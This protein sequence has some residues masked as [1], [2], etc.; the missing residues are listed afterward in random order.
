MRFLKLGAGL[1]SQKFDLEALNFG[2]K[3][4]KKNLDVCISILGNTVIFFSI[5]LLNQLSPVLIKTAFW[6]MEILRKMV[7]QN[8]QNSLARKISV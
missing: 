5:H 6:N 8:L 3:V 7:L 2:K 4:K 1:K